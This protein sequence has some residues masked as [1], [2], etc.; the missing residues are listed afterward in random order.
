MLRDI[1]ESKWSYLRTLSGRYETRNTIKD[2]PR[3]LKYWSEIGVVRRQK[4][5]V[6]N[7][8]F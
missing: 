5:N 3:A 4:R 6:S 2:P 7:G 8:G 1:N